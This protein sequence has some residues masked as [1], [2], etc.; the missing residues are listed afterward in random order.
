MAVEFDPY[1]CPLGVGNEK[2]IEHV[3]EKLDMAIQRLEEKMDDMKSDLTSHM[4][5]GFSNVNGKL[6]KVDERLT[7][8]ENNLDTRIENKVKQIHGNL[9]LKVVGWVFGSMGA[10]VA[11]SVVTKLILQALKLGW[12][13]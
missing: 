9:V 7:N 1:T 10:A 5:D 2:S 12:S 6:D 11:I 8:L 3:G 13:F 4:N